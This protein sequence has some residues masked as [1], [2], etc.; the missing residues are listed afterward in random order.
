M[1]MN[2]TRIHNRIE[3]RRKQSAHRLV[4][5]VSSLPREWLPRVLPWL[6]PAEADAVNARVRGREWKRAN[7]PRAREVARLA[8][9]RAARQAAQRDEL[10]RAVAAARETPGGAARFAAATSYTQRELQPFLTRQEKAQLAAIRADEITR[11]K[12]LEI[13]GCSPTEFNRWCERKRLP[14]HRTKKLQGQKAARTFLRSEIEP[15]RACV[16][17]WRQQDAIMKLNR[18]YGLRAV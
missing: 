12:V 9:E 13:L 4:L 1:S 6:T 10:A 15:L 5:Y 8:A 14:M 7:N 18:R 3:M 11:A 2:A 16:E 17:T